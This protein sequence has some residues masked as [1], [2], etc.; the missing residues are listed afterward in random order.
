MENNYYSFITPRWEMMMY[1]LAKF[2][3]MYKHLPSSF[4]CFLF[5]QILPAYSNSNGCSYTGDHQPGAL[6]HAL[7][8]LFPRKKM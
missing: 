3:Y 8:G 2:Y 4:I 7:S 6:S 1:V 5:A